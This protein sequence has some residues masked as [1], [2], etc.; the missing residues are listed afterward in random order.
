LSQQAAGLK[1]LTVLLRSFADPIDK[2]SMS[3]RTTSTAQSRQRLN[4][5]PRRDPARPQVN[6][7]APTRKRSRRR[8]AASARIVLLP[9]FH[10]EITRE[11]VLQST[12]ARQADRITIAYHSP[13]VEFDLSARGKT[14]LAGT[15]D[16]ELTIDG[17]PQVCRGDWQSV[18]WYGDDDGDYL[19]LRLALSDRVWIDR[20]MLLS[21]RGHFA[22][23]ADA[24]VARD[25][26][27]MEYR[28]ILPTADGVAMKFDSR[29]R[30]CRLVTAGS[31]ARVFPL[32]LPQ[33]RVLSTAGG[34]IE[35]DGG[36]ELAQAGAG[37]GL[38]APILIDWH[39]RRRT[40]AAEW[41]S[42]TVTELGKVI[43]RDRAAGHRLRLAEHQLLIYKSLDT[44]EEARA[45]L[46]HHTHYESVIGTFDS[47]GEV[48][49]IVLVETE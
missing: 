30:E 31:S 23:L 18:C 49:P 36:L 9:S 20:Q 27:R 25:A 42:L 19:E 28:M 33:E 40:T 38:Y 41:R 5:A 13:E 44:A 46:G 7:I 11:V 14:L 26:K 47:A 6:G 8:P 16:G 22:L 17:M 12:A 21:R 2:T 10:S 32:A 37:W 24:V 48:D 45:V 15:I 39:P 43:S 35:C 34:F 4:G 3:T 29:T 1:I